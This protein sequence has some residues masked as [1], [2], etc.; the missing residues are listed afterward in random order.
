MADAALFGVR[1]SYERDGL[2]V[3]EEVE[4]PPFGEDGVRHRTRRTPGSELNEGDDIVWRHGPVLA[5]VSMQSRNEPNALEIAAKQHAKAVA[6]FGA[7]Y[8]PPIEPPVPPI[9]R[10][11][12]P[13]SH[14]IKAVRT[15]HGTLTYNRPMDDGYDEAIAEACFNAE[16]SAQYSG[17]RRATDRAPWTWDEPGTK[18]Q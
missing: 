9:P 8:A 18:A 16:S 14:P 15:D 12:C 3:I 2:I 11:D 5:S 1:G 7:T 13:P 17:Y 6:V 10:P 4:Q